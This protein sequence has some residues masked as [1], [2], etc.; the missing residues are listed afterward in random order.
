MPDFS[1]V[2]DHHTGP[3]KPNLSGIPDDSAPR[4]RP[5]PKTLPFK[6]IGCLTVV[7]FLIFLLLVSNARNPGPLPPPPAPVVRPTP[8]PPPP[9]PVVQRTAEYSQRFVS[10]DEFGERW[11]VT[12]KDGWVRAYR[13]P[14]KITFLHGGSEYAVNGI[15][16]GKAFGFTPV[17]AIH[18]QGDWSDLGVFLSI[19]LELQQQ[20]GYS[21][22][23]R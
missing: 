4:V 7:G 13:F 12:V 10:S 3:K 11:P 20:A 2:D 23:Q 6:R 15:A 22:N 21:P 8:P 9:A 1:F 16:R 14:T 18:R 17:D 19:G 5:P